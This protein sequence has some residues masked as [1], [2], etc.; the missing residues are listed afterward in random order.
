MKQS[1]SKTFTV[2]TRLYNPA[3]DGS[4]VMAE[5]AGSGGDINPFRK[6][7]HDHGDLH[8]RRLQPVQRRAIPAGSAA[9]TCLALEVENLLLAATAVADQSMNCRVSNGEV[10]T[11]WVETG[12]TAGINDFRTAAAALALRPGQ[13]IQFLVMGEKADIAITLRAL[14]RRF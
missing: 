14:G 12:M 7:S 4:V 6:G 8:Q 10:I 3:G 9:A 2:A 1:L 11:Q 13:H 5:D